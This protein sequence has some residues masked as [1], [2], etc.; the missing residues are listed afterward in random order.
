MKK[1]KQRSVERI[2]FHNRK[3]Q[4]SFIEFVL[5]FLLFGF[6]FTSINYS[7]SISEEDRKYSVDSFLDS[8]YYDSEVRNLSLDE[9]L[10]SSSLTENWDNVEIYLNSTFLNYEL[11]ISNSLDSKKIFNC[12][13]DYEKYFSERIISIKNNTNFEF[14]KVTLGVCY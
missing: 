4:V 12:N 5:I 8:L 7:N 13:E 11:I 14:R 6:L 10:S 2:Y 1:I 3:C 9:N